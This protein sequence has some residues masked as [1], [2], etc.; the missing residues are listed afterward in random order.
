MKTAIYN[1]LGLQKAIGEL[2]AMF[3]ASRYVRIQASDSKPRSLN[4]NALA[5]AWYAQIARELGE[6]T[7]HGV[8]CECKLRYGVPIMRADDEEF[9]ERYDLVIKP[10]SYE[11]KVKAMGLMPVTS[12]MNTDQLSRYL[13]C[14]QDGYRGRVQL[15]FPEEIAREHA[16]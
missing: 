15:E 2:R 1:E 13:Q 5:H 12:Q 11:L 16:A 6:D 9:R 8:K 14:M 7:E 10:L 4:Q 3:K